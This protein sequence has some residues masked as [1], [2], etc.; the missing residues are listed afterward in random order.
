MSLPVEEL[1]LNAVGHSHRQAGRLAVLSRA[2]RTTA[3]VTDEGPGIA[4]TMRT[5]FEGRDDQLLKEAFAAGVTSTDDP[6][7]GWG[8]TRVLS[9]VE[10][11]TGSLSVES[12]VAVGFYDGAEFWCLT[13]S[14]RQMA[15]TTV[16]IRHP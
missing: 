9:W 16:Q 4:E 7:R 14:D 13:K 3:T 11:H 8:L 6:R 2:G 1:M 10:I 15:G 12:G 5:R